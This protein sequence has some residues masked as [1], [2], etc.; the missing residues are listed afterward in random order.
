MGRRISWTGSHADLMDRHSYL[1][2]RHSGC[3]PMDDPM[4]DDPMDDPMDRH[5]DLALSRSRGQAQRARQER[6]SHGQAQQAWR[7]TGTD[8]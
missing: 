4:D 5:R 7:L 8:G 1:V 3:D 2:D 6:R